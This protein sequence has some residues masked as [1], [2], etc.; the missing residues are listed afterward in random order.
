MKRLEVR[1]PEA[2][3]DILFVVVAAADNSFAVNGTHNCCLQWEFPYKS[4]MVAMRCT[5]AVAEHRM[6]PLHNRDENSQTAP[7]FAVAVAVTDSSAAFVGKQNSGVA[8][9][10]R[11]AWS[12]NMDAAAVAWQWSAAEPAAPLHSPAHT[13]DEQEP[14][15]T[16]SLETIHVFHRKTMG[17]FRLSRVGYRES[18][19][20]HLA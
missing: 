7:E 10:V 3:A 9:A 5:A 16:Y 13:V 11:H 15:W 2:A 8:V 17:E 19:L 4:M 14:T 1:R 12:S 18:K 20:G 6:A